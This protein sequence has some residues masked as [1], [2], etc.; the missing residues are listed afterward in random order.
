MISISGGEHLV[1]QQKP[2]IWVTDDISIK[3]NNT[4]SVRINSQV[5]LDIIERASALLRTLE[6]VKRYEDNGEYV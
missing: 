3:F 6:T 4:N 5:T 2:E 1:V